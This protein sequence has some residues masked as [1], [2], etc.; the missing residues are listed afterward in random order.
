MQCFT[1]TLHDKRRS[2]YFHIYLLK[3]LKILLQTWHTIA[4]LIVTIIIIIE[5]DL[6]RLELLYYCWNMS[7]TY[8]LAKHQIDALPNINDHVLRRYKSIS[9]L[10]TSD[11]S[12]DGPGMVQA[13][14]TCPRLTNQLQTPSTAWLINLKRL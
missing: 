1:T 12:R 6:V 5:V 11:S 14:L 8:S 10:Q 7:K 4:V 2:I 9:C 3:H 13:K